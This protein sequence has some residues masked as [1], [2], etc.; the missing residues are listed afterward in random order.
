MTVTGW[1]LFFVIIEKEFRWRERVY[2]AKVLRK[3]TKQT[4]IASVVYVLIFFL[5]NL[6]ELFL[7]RSSQGFQTHTGVKMA[8]DGAATLFPAHFSLTQVTLI[9]YLIFIFIWLMAYFRFVYGKELPDPIDFI[10]AFFN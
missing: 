1:W 4:S 6:V 8:F 9:L 3:L 2:M 5:D 10:L 7:N